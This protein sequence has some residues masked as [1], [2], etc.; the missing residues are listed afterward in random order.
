MKKALIVGS[1]SQDGIFLKKYLLSLKYDVVGICRDYT[2]Y[3]GLINRN[4]KINIL[5]EDHIESFIE[6]EK[7]DE[8]YYFS[9]YNHS[10]ESLISENKQALEL[11]N[12]L[13][14][15][16]PMIFLQV[17]K[18]V[19]MNIKFFYA[20][21]SH[22][23]G[24]YSK[25]PQNEL[26][27]INPNSVYGITKASGLFGCRKYRNEN[28][29]VSTGI[30]YS[31]VSEN[32]SQKFLSKKITSAVARINA[33]SDEIISI[34]NLDTIID[35][36]YA[37]NYVE[38]MHAILQLPNSDDFIISSGFSHTVKDFISLAFDCVGL[39]Y[40]NHIKVDKNLLKRN[41]N[42]LVG[43]SKKVFESTGWR[44]KTTFTEMVRIL[45]K[46]EIE[47]L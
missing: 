29:F 32:R 43:D 30:L 40:R 24:N 22:I 28:V 7:P 46:Y 11:A 45:V 36:G 16:S 17:I 44:P 31:H 14:F 10:S 38:A 12:N 2:E 15:I 13:H 19:K 26:T 27:Q 39:D 18:K 33:G 23:F 21:S 35:W 4:K 5:R 20:C 41:F 42:P 34:G 47:S 6:K 1:R 9:S 37:K 3:S 8:I 25:Y